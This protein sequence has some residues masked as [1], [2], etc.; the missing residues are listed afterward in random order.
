MIKFEVGILHHSN[1]R[2]ICSHI[3]QMSSQQCCWR[4]PPWNASHGIFLLVSSFRNALALVLQSKRWNSTQEGWDPYPL[5]LACSLQS[6]IHNLRSGTSEWPTRGSSPLLLWVYFCGCCNEHGLFI[7]STGRIQSSHRQSCGSVSCLVWALSCTSCS[8][9]SADL[10]TFAWWITGKRV[11]FWLLLLYLSGTHGHVIIEAHGFAFQ[12]ILKLLE[13]SCLKAVIL[14]ALT[15]WHS[16]SMNFCMEKRVSVP[17]SLRT[18]VP[19]FEKEGGGPPPA[20]EEEA[21]EPGGT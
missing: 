8:P 18:E 20:R 15:S 9:S 11:L 3:R 6:R 17:M 1:C 7:T 4:Q 10:L 14:S 16:F 21:E 2:D 5:A 13:H 12:L 19:S